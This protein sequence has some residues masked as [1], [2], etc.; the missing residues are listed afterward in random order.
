MKILVVTVAFGSYHSFIPY[1]IFTTLLK[2]PHYYVKVITDKKSVELLAALQIIRV[3]LSSNFELCVEPKIN[4]KEEVVPHYFYGKYYKIIMDDKLFEGFD[5][6]Y[7]ADVD[8]IFL[9]ADK[10]RVE[11]GISIIEKLD[12]TF[13]NNLVSIK[14]VKERLCNASHLINVKKYV[15]KYGQTLK[16]YR[17]NIDAVKK[18]G[19]MD[20]KFLYH[21]MDKD[22]IKKIEDSGM[23]VPYMGF[24]LGIL[25]VSNREEHAKFLLKKNDAIEIIKHKIFMDIYQLINNK[26]I[27]KMVNLLL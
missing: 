12:T 21:I 16:Y 10:N 13:Y 22:E 23:K 11:A 26:N 3:Q 17:E 24:N 18:L 27:A 7:F 6:V 4:F 20:E 1:F 14:G 19:L 5:Y 8:H 25:R 9:S 2:N 15:K